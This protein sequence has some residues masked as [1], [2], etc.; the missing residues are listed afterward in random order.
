ML[1]YIDALGG[2]ELAD[3]PHEKLAAYVSR[4]RAE[5]GLSLH[6][7]RRRGDIPTSTVHKIERP[8]TA[9]LPKYDTLMRLARGL[10]VSPDEL[11]DIVGYKAHAVESPSDQKHGNHGAIMVLGNIAPGGNNQDHGSAP[12]LGENP[13]A[14]EGMIRPWGQLD[15]ISRTVD[16]PILGTAACGEPI[17]VIMDRA[18]DFLTIDARRTKGAEA[19]MLIEGDSM[20]GAGLLHGDC[21]LVKLANGT[22]PTSG[23]LVIVRTPDGLA[24]KR[25]RED[26]LG[27]YLEEHAAGQDVRR[28]KYDD[29]ELVGLVV[30]FYRDL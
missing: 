19:A 5:K 26:D 20:T 17:A 1:F 12:L 8:R 24:C 18:T 28:V 30:G 22:R 23:K 21:V 25:F 10:G 11:L 2:I 3:A 4:V 7:V 9:T 14:A 15:R 13:A 6:D 27:T 16:L 29:A